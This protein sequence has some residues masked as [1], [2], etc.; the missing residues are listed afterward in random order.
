MAVTRPNVSEPPGGW[1]N[2]RR[3]QFEAEPT[4]EQH[5]VAHDFGQAEIVLP[6]DGPG[7][8]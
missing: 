8:A 2:P 1:F 5:I 4:A 3:Q 7:S 6:E